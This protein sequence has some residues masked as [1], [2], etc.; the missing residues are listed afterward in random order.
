MDYIR[1]GF[2][3]RSTVFWVII[4]H[5]VIKGYIFLTGEICF[6]YFPGHDVYNLYLPLYSCPNVPG[7][8]YLQS[9]GLHRIEETSTFLEFHDYGGNE[10][11]Y[12]YRNRYHHIY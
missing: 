2:I 9:N 12:Q 5:E 11:I 3:F 1:G 8:T 4:M 7:H 10:R 6:L